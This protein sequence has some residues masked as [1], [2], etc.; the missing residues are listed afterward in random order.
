MSGTPL[1]I[2][3][4]VNPR[5]VGGTEH[6]LASLLTALDRD[7]VRPVA[8]FSDEGPTTALF[9]SRGLDVAIVPY[10]ETETSPNGVVPFL[11]Q[12]QIDIVQSSYF[13]PVLGLAAAQASL[14]HVWR[15]GGHV[16]VVYADRS[17]RDMQV[18]LSLVTM[19]SQRIVCA[20]DFLRR[21]FN[22]IGHD[23]AQVIFNGLDPL[24]FGSPADL[25]AVAP[26]VA[27]VAHYV[28][29]KRHEDLIR[30]TAIVAREVAGLRVDLFG[31]CY[32]SE[33]SERYAERLRQLVADLGLSDVVHFSHLGAERRTT[34]ASVALCVLPSVNEGASNAIVEA[35]AF[36]KP[37]IAAASGGNPELVI[38]GETGFLVPP[39][40][41]ERLAERMLALLG[42]PA[43]RVQCGRAAHRRVAEQFHIGR[44]AR[45]YERLYV[46]MARRRAGSTEAPA[47]MA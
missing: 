31:A 2:A 27:M 43:L 45:E 9:R 40:S 29:Q 25:S 6:F 15:F 14:P 13:S 21:Q 41:P 1:R 38:E 19:L 5:I 4:E 17:E 18:F 12:R 10:T 16:S 37:V 26:R 46:S 24:E 42:S 22:L 47:R 35:M 3:V 7:R 30:A 44:C 34:M 23:A 20:S 33:E 36:G 11:R 32:P 28:P 8:L 39:E